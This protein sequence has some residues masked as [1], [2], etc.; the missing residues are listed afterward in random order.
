M[1]ASVRSS[2]DRVEQTRTEAGSRPHWHTQTSIGSASSSRWSLPASSHLH[3]VPPG[4]S[5]RSP[6]SCALIGVP[7][8]HAPIC[9]QLTWELVRQDAG[10]SEHRSDLRRVFDIQG[11]SPL[12]DLARVQRQLQLTSGRC[13]RAAAP[14]SRLQRTR[15]QA[16]EPFCSAAFQA[17]L[18]IGPSTWIRRN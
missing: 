17:L 2:S 12:H 11:L 4:S 13:S 18:H 9:A 6:G 8:R 3:T 1:R 5:K 14:S 15:A 10:S 16:T 7:S